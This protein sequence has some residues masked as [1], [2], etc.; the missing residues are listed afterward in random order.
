MAFK[1]DLKRYLI[2]WKQSEIIY[3]PKRS[4]TVLQRGNT[5]ASVARKTNNKTNTFQPLMSFKAIL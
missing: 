4:K 5:I 2:E 3:H 1:N